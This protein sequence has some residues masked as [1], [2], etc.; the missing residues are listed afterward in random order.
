VNNLIKIKLSEKITRTSSVCSF[1]FIAD[2]KVE[3]LPGQFAR[4]IF[5]EEAI[6]N[7]SLNKY[8]SISCSPERGYLEF[9][10][11]ITAS[12]FSKHLMALAVGDV[13]N[14]AR[15]SGHC[16]FDE[17]LDGMVFLVG[18]IG[19]TPVISMLEYIADK[20]FKN[21]MDIF[22][23]NETDKDVPFKNILDSWTRDNEALR[24]HYN[25]TGCVEN[26]EGCFRGRINSDYI[27][28]KVPDIKERTAFIFG[29]PA[30]VEAMKDICESM[31]DCPVKMKYESFVGY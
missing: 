24:V 9:T 21:K 12:D 3:F 14:M 25:F 29:P 30:M 28:N 19:I 2:K 27:L 6:N 1:R 11:R 7:S 8:L 17:S 5:D 31:G 16:V 26:D 18:G 15:P 13:I 10:K 20:K 23:S 4:I 22:Y